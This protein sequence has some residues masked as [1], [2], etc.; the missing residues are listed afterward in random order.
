MI[1][2]NDIRWC[3]I[4]ITVRGCESL[5]Y[6]IVKKA[7]KNGRLIVYYLDDDLLNVP[8]GP[9]CPHEYYESVI[10]K[11]MTNILGNAKILWGVNPLICEKYLKYT[12]SGRWL[13]NKVVM[14]LK[15]YHMNR[16]GDGK[17][18]ILY[19]GSS[20]HQDNVR[21]ILAPAV[22]IIAERYREKVEFVFVGVDSGI[23][24][25]EN[26]KHYSI[27]KDYNDYR[28]FVENGR[29]SFGL[30]VVKT[31]EFYQCKYYN[32]FLEYTSIGCLGIYTDSKPYTYVVKDKINGIL[33][34]NNQSDWYDAICFAI[35]HID[36]C[37][38]MFEKA[39]EYVAEYHNTEFAS[40]QLEHDFPELITYSAP[41][42]SRLNVISINPK[43]FF[44]QS[45]VREI[46]SYNG[47]FKGSL[48]IIFK[49]IKY[50]VNKFAGG[51]RC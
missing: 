29:F 40:K 48:I 3:D 30:A 24:D 50:V 34:N 14:P 16:S 8:I 46:L 25:M 31:E 38:I 43:I 47:F 49:G 51:K 26:V 9:A 42:I 22:K 11:N 2:G 41:E 35:D 12:D 20:S 17:V 10:R 18:R 28:N 4:L 44:F 32:K 27:F 45:R 21:S 23:N 37:S 5:T 6:S 33:C 13:D 15:S 19:A 1:K 36:E 7:R 39:K